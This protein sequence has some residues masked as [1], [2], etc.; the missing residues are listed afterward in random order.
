M[1]RCMPEPVSATVAPGLTGGPSASPVTLKEPPV[2]CATQSK[3]L[4]EL[5][6]PYVPKPLIVP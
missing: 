6:G 5:Y 4:N 1:A 3:H 2:A